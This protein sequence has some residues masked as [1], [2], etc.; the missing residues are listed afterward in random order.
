MDDKYIKLKHFEE[1]IQLIDKRDSVFEWSEEWSKYDKKVKNTIE[2]L[3]R[4]AK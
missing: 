1:L 4:N 3:R 2:W